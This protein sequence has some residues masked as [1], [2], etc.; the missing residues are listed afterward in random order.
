MENLKHLVWIHYHHAHIFRMISQIFLR[1]SLC[2]SFCRSWLSAVPCRVG[3]FWSVVFLPVQVSAQLGRKLGVLQVQRSIAGCRQQPDRS[4]G[5]HPTHVLPSPWTV[6]M[7]LTKMA[8]DLHDI[9]LWMPLS[10]LEL[11]DWKGGFEILDRAA[12][13]RSHVD[14][15]QQ[16]SAGNEVIPL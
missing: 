7:L 14:L 2:L 5:S 11:S 10:L 1:T 6:T 4:G 16:H 13:Q 9:V 15:G 12:S 8:N 3:A